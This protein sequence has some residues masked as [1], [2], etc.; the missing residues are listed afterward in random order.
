MLPEYAAVPSR[1]KFAAVLAPDRRA[2]I[3]DLLTAAAAWCVPDV[4]VGDC[5][6]VKDDI[7]L[8]LALAAGATAIVTGDED[9][10]V[11]DPW[12]GVRVLR[13]AACLTHLGAASGG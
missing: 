2:E 7:Y 6:D 1:P 12:R 3:L 13:P 9:L 4:A 11:L 10:L 5:R 8:E